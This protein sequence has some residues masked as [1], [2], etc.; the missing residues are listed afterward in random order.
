V[1]LR[2]LTK[3]AEDAA[4]IAVGVGVLTYQKIATQVTAIADRTPGLELGATVR[5]RFEQAQKELEARIEPVVEAIEGRLPE[6]ARSAVATGRKMADEARAQI[7]AR[8]AA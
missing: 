2:D 3:T 4:Y 6:Q 7:R 5:A 1:Q 8:L